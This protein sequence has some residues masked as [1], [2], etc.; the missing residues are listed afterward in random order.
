[1]TNLVE[2]QQ[3]RIN[4]SIGGETVQKKRAR[5]TWSSASQKR[6]LAP[7]VNVKV[8]YPTCRTTRNPFLRGDNILF[9][10][11]LHTLV[12]A[13]AAEGAIDAASILK[14][15]LARGELHTIGATTLDEYRKH[16][17]KDAALERRFQKIV[18][19]EP[20]VTHT[21]EILRG[22]RELIVRI[23]GALKVH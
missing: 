17:E 23:K 11:E 9:I 4:D 1:M 15:M 10:D 16:L 20:T 3:Y 8:P 14:P 6:L 13:G 5:L 22:L 21:I 19:D 2:Q 12:G 7:G 18:V